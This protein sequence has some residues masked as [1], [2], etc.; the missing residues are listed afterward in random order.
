MTVILT[1]NVHHFLQGCEHMLIAVTLYCLNAQ[2]TMKII[3]KQNETHQIANITISLIHCWK[4]GPHYVKLIIL[5]KQK[6]ERQ[7]YFGWQAKCI[8]SCTLTYSWGNLWRFWI[9]SRGDL[10]YKFAYSYSSLN[11]FNGSKTK[12]NCP[13]SSVWIYSVM[14][15]HI[16][17]LHL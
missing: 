10:K 12:C 14:H 3:S 17:Y 11:T 16:H 6:L 4:C 15:E 2:S 13:V 5:W 9:L 8:H 1:I 7:H